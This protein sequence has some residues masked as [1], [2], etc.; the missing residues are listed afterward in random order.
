MD[1]LKYSGVTLTRFL[2]PRI[3]HM[4]FCEKA[5]L[6]NSPLLLTN[7]LANLNFFTK[8]EIIIPFFNLRALIIIASLLCISATRSIFVILLLPTR[9]LH[10]DTWLE[11]EIDIALT[12]L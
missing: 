5:D 10:A 9:P 2:I 12:F 11:D 8:Q 7:R 4:L 3:A 1:H 6:L